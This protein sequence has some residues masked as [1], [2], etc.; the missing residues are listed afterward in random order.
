GKMP[1]AWSPD[2]KWLAYGK[3]GSNGFRRIVLWSAETGDLR[4]VTDALA[5]AHSPAWDRGGRYLY[6]LA[7]TDLA[8]GSGFANTSAVRSDP[9]Y[10]AYMAVLRAEDPSP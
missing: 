7:S 4:E 2:S 9:T 1:L 10:G 3:T 6:F 8:L 5:D